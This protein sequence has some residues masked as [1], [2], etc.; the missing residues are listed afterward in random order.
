MVDG[1]KDSEIDENGL[2]THYFREER[3][4]EGNTF[5]TSLITSDSRL[6]E[7]FEHHKNLVSAVVEADY[8]L[9]KRQATSV[10]ELDR[11]HYVISLR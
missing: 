11:D 10:I 3:I 7:A 8:E 2:C 4:I 9:L 6:V 1:W 5:E